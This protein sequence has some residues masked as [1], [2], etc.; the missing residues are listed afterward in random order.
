MYISNQRTA[1]PISHPASTFSVMFL[2]YHPSR[3]CSIFISARPLTDPTE[4]R[5]PPMAVH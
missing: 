3:M 2:R 5:Q 4:S 1:K